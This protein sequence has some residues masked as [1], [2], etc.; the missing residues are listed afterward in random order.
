MWVGCDT[1]DATWWEEW[2][3]KQQDWE[4]HDTAGQAWCLHLE[5]DSTS[6]KTSLDVRQPHHNNQCSP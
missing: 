1:E 6:Q 4:G 5:L 2:D 3:T